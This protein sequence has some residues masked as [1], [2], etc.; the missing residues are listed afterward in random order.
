M[1]Q[2][3]RP[4][5]LIPSHIDL[6]DYPFMPAEGDRLRRSRAWSVIAKRDP[7]LGFYM[8]NLWW[9]SWHELPAGSLEDDDDVLCELAMCQ[10]TETWLSVKEKVM[11]GWVLCSDGRWYHPVVCEKAE[12]AW[13]RKNRQR[14][15]TAAARSAREAKR[16]ADIPPKPPTAPPPPPPPPAPPDGGKRTKAKAEDKQASFLPD[17]VDEAVHLYNEAAE[18]VGLPKAMRIS[19]PRKSK[20]KQRL[21]D[22]G[23]IEGWKAA[24]A[25]MEASSFC[26]GRKTDFR[27]H[28]DFLLQD[29]SFTK[30]MEGAYDDRKP[31]PGGSG[32]SP[33]GL[34]QVFGNVIRM[35]D[36]EGS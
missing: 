6:R 3:K 1:A 5:P 28:L 29:S 16:R 7:R 34:Q 36:R 14:Q 2:Q 26:C 17:A 27:A 13:E 10:D 15:Q 24:L 22:A 25:K 21:H 8:W 33:T 11:H 20:L 19:D 31:S 9:M 4:D 30:L 12:E 35:M 18:R 23:G 32:G